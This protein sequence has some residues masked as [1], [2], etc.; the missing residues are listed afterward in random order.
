MQ[1]F[2]EFFRVNEDF[3]LDDKPSREDADKIQRLVR[4][5]KDINNRV[6]R[7]Q[8]ELEQHDFSREEAEI[9]KS[10]IATLARDLESTRL[11]PDAEGMAGTGYTA[12]SGLKFN[13]EQVQ[14]TVR[15]AAEIL[16]S[17]IKS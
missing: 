9:L 13:D 12:L 7:V 14:N 8:S 3:N 16:M 15:E 2:K 5:V 11:P 1:T 17:I 4:L 10:E 6:D